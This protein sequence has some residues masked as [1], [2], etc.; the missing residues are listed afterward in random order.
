[1]F[2]YVI[3]VEIF[4]NIFLILFFYYKQPLVSSIYMERKVIESSEFSLTNY[5]WAFTTVFYFRNIRDIFRKISKVY[6]VLCAMYGDDVI[7]FF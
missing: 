3:F 7:G 5:E 1:M 2:F 6:V 4:Y